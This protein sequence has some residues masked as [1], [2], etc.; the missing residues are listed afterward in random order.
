LWDVEVAH[1]S[2]IIIL[3]RFP[4]VGPPADM[5]DLMPKYDHR[6]IRQGLTQA[7]QGLV[8][9]MVWACPDVGTG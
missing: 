2:R 8:P 7:E 6:L 4:G 3:G 5:G 1:V 9:I